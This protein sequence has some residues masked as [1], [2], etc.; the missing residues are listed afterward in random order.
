MQ[1]SSNDID[2]NPG[3]KEVVASATAL[4]PA[5]NAIMHPI[6]IPT[7]SFLKILENVV[8]PIVLITILENPISNVEK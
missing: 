6:A 4:P 3:N 8:T 1:I 2:K 7:F 5:P